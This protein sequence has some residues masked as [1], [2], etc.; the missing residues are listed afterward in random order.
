[1]LKK[2][3]I[4][5]NLVAIF[6][7]FQTDVKEII[8]LQLAEDAISDPPDFQEKVNGYIRNGLVE[9]SRQV[10]ETVKAHKK[11]DDGFDP[12]REDDIWLGDWLLRM[13]K[14]LDIELSETPVISY[15]FKTENGYQLEIRVKR[16]GELYD[17][18]VSFNYANSAEKRYALD[19][20]V[21]CYKWLR[22][23]FPEVGTEE[24]ESDLILISRHY[25]VAQVHKRL[26]YL[27]RIIMKTSIEHFFCVR[28]KYFI[29]Q[30]NFFRRRLWYWFKAR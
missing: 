21:E 12:E 3:P 8:R 20:I 17:E 24:K 2:R 30:F 14:M 9:T 15:P 29:L 23:A 16:I 4:N 28:L 1:M 13:L 27:P 10:F 5:P 22:E 19:R 6:N 18:L 7:V 11:N 25:F 26:E